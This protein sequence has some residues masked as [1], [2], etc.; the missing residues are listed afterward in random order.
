MDSLKIPALSFSLEKLNTQLGNLVISVPQ[1]YVERLYFQ[2]SEA[3]QIKSHIYGFAKGQAPINYIEKNFQPHLLDHVKEFF[4]KYLI[5]SWLHEQIL[6]HKILLAGEPRLTQIFIT[7]GQNASFHFSI[8]LAQPI[9]LQGWK[10]LIFKAPKRK[11]YKDLDRQVEHFL[12]NENDAAKLIKDNTI[13][14]GDWINF[15]VS[16]LDKNKNPLFEGFS[17][18]LWLKIGSEEADGPFQNLFVGKKV[19]DKIITDHIGLQEHF[20]THLDTHYLFA[21]EILDHLSH[22]YFCLEH[23]KR[24]FKLKSN[25]EIHQKFIEVF[26]YRNDISQRRATSEEALKLL[27]SKYTFSVPLY[28]VLRQEKAILEMVHEQSDYHVYKTQPDFREKITVLAEKQ[29]KENILIQQ[30]A[31][32]EGIQIK[33]A[34]IKA[35]LNLTNRPRTSEFIYF[36]PPTTKFSGQETPISE[37]LMIQSCLKEKTLNHAIYHLTKK[38]SGL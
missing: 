13:A 32:L 9:L 33:N 29:L 4:F 8:T 5:I 3:Q 27:L 25:K 38:Q 16:L 26:S 35:Y 6:T 20:S 36:E 30:L 11:N 18:K 1:L 24:H 15:S 34:D 22:G 31:Y 12:K 17:E 7:P 23:F 19:G 21:V 37:S 2:A 10:R 14:I 28:V